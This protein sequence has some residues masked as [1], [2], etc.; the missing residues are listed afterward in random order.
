MSMLTPRFQFPPTNDDL[1]HG[2]FNQI[3]HIRSEADEVL[4]AYIEREG[5]ERLIEELWD[6]CWCVET[7]LRRFPWRKVVKGF[8]YCIEK[9]RKRDYVTA[10]R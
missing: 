9:N 3:Q 2:T 1:Y 6:V 10:R 7:L 4:D 8:R 5:D